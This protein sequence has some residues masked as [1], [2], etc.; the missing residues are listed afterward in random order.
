[1]PTKSIFHRTKSF[2]DRVAANYQRGFGPRRVVMLLKTIGRKSGLPRMT[3][4]LFEK[5]GE[6]YIIASVRGCETDCRFQ[7]AAL[8]SPP[9][10]GAAQELPR[11]RGQLAT[12]DHGVHT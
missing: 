12:W 6:T 11:I 2:N 7:R 1:M 4:L 8:A 3:P 9:I 10:D 5:V